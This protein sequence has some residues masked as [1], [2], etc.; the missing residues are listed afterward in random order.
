MTTNNIN[1]EGNEP[2]SQDANSSQ[3]QNGAL[4]SIE[5]QSRLAD[6]LGDDP[7][8]SQAEPD[9]SD[10]NQSEDQQSDSESETDTNNDDDGE[11]EVHS[12]SEEE[13]SSED[14]SRGVQKRIDKLT[15][16][17][18]EAEEQLETMRKEVED[19]KASQSQRVV[20][21]EI[22]DVPH[23]NLESVAEIEAEIAQARAVRNW[24]EQNA[25]GFTQTNEDGSETYYDPA[26]VRQIKVNAMKALEESLP[27][28]YQ[29][30]SHRDSLEPVVAKEYPWWKDK[31]SQER[32]IA[33]KFISSFPAIKRFPD[34][35][36]VIGDYIRGVRAREANF[37]G[38]K[39]IP[40]APSIPRTTSS[41]PTVKK[42]ELQSR[43]AYS[44]FKKTGRTDDLSRI[45]EDFL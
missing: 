44:Q 20:N 45:I 28:R 7:L 26:Q 12:Q 27:Q 3:E 37:K 13:D 2:S 35:K 4:S 5:L 42:Q 29:Y 31:S 39:N 15:A 40:K 30:I 32:V 11:K 43:D 18:K 34:Y 19:L 10:S 23:S 17:R 38:Q 14:L 6:I 41:A 8:L 22:P 24:S 36:M 9:E 21:N 33:E 16:K 1:G 25:D